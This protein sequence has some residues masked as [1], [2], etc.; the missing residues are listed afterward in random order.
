MLT[1]KVCLQVTGIRPLTN[2]I[3][4]S[5]YTGLSKGSTAVVLLLFNLM[6]NVLEREWFLEKRSY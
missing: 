3:S 5:I 4:S 1:K 6:N 2:I